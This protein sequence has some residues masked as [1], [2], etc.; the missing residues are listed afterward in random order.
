[1]REVCVTSENLNLLI[2]AGQLL[3]AV[4]FFLN[5]DKEYVKKRLPNIRIMS[6]A[7]YVLILGGF[8]F[9]GYGFYLAN[10]RPKTVEKIVEKQVPVEKVIQQECPSPPPVKPRAAKPVAKNSPLPAQQPAENTKPQEP[11]QSCPNGICIGGNNSGNPTVINTKIPLPH[12]FWEPNTVDV[13]RKQNGHPVTYAKVW[14]DGLFDSPAFA[15]ICDRPCKG[16]NFSV[17]GYNENCWGNLTGEDKVA[18]F[19]LMAHN[20]FPSGVKADAGV[21]SDDDTQVKVLAVKTLSFSDPTRRT[22]ER[23]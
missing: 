21:V 6:A 17:N 9:A 15:V 23:H 20:P 12:V 22:C 10:R 8:V 1:L 3:F 5:I 19:I 11:T 4:L 16:Y 18:G 13:D 14:T 2:G 7:I